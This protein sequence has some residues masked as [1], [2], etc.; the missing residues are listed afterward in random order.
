MQRTLLTWACIRRL[1]G[2]SASGELLHSLYCSMYCTDF[3]FLVWPS[4]NLANWV[5]HVESRIMFFGY[6]GYVL[7]FLAD[8]ELLRRLSIEGF[9]FAKQ[10]D[11]I[12]W[13][14][15][16]LYHFHL[17]EYYRLIKGWCLFHRS[18]ESVTQYLY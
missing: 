17:S 4:W 15:Y 12:F 5:N 11:M 6:S 1:T 13:R 10:H 2:V 18:N 16:C 14:K 8:W 7:T 9:A 3:A